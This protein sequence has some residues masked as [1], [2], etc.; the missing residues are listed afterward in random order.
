M[1]ITDILFAKSL[2]SGG[3]GGGGDFPIWKVE[4]NFTSTD[5]LNTR[6]IEFYG[7]K[8]SDTG[9]I[10]ALIPW[11]NAYFD[12]LSEEIPIGETIFNILVINPDSASLSFYVAEGLGI[13]ITTS[14]NI[15]YDEEREEYVI[16]GDCEVNIVKE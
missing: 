4:I 8:D 2:S 14:G 12:E 1:D 11:N 10:L 6:P 7:G 16:T 13:S 3:G 15:V 5:S 9:E